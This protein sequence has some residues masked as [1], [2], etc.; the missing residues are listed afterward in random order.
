MSFTVERKIEICKQN[1]N[2]PGCCWYLCD[3]PKQSSCKNCYS[4]YSNCPHDVYEVINDEPLPIHQENCVGCKIC[5][6]MCPTHAIYVDLLLMRV[7]E[8][9]QIQQWL[10]SNVKARPEHIRCEVAD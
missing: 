4:C 1:N 7:G 3:N 2:R 6:E 10:K 9:G 8:S 5:E